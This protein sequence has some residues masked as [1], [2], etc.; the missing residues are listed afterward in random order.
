MVEFEAV[1]FYRPVFVVELILASVAPSV[2]IARLVGLLGREDVVQSRPHQD[3][4][5]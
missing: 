3:N 4:P 1:R 2:T 5:D